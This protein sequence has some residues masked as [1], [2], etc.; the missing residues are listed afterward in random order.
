MQSGE[1]R[2]RRGGPCAWGLSE[3]MQGDGLEGLQEQSI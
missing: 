2:Q 1:K 3:G